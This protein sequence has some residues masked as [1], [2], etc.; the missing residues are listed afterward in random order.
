MKCRVIN[1]NID[2]GNGDFFVNNDDILKIIETET[3]NQIGKTSNEISLARIEAAIRKEPHIS[4]A[5]ASL[6]LDGQLTIDIMQKRAV[7]RIINNVGES[8]YLNEDGDVMPL[9]DIYAASVPVATGN[10]TETEA[11]FSYRSLNIPETD[12]MANITVLDDIFRISK[13]IEKDTFWNAQ[14][15][16]MVVDPKGDILLIPTMGEHTIVFGKAIDID[17]K[18]NKL[19]H[20]YMEGLNKT[21]WN[22]YSIINL[23]YKN[24]VVCLRKGIQPQVPT[25]K[26][27]TA[28]TNSPNIQR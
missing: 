19:M 8:F 18:F 9:S 2:H 17:E 12:P 13:Y 3:G 4:N 1:I 28:L 7:V 24:Q 16:Q 20:F 23:N 11:L 21:G 15:Q 26:P 14:I 25:T 27:D 22:K 6:S 5:E 10:I